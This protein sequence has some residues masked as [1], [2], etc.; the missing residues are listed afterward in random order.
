MEKNCKKKLENGYNVI[1]IS[2]WAYDVFFN[3]R[4]DL[5]NEMEEL[6]Q[7]LFFMEDD[8]QFEYTES[9]LKLL[10]KKLINNEENPLQQI[11][12]MKSKK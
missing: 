10:A 9:E 8:P 4:R 11:I 7:Y 5:S 2:R 3:H 1:S 12:D 6:L